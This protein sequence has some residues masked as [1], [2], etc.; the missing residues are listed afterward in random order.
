MEQKIILITGANSGIGKAAAQQ[1]VQKGNHTILACRNEEKGLAA[2]KEINDTTGMDNLE[3]MIMDMSLQS[4]IQ[5]LA[6]NFE[7]KFDHLDVIIH[8]AAIFDISQKE[9]SFTAEGVESIWATNHIGPVLL[10]RLLAN[11][12]EKSDHGRIITIASKGLMA[13]PFLKVDLVDPEFKAR[14]YSV[15]HAYYQSKLA[16]IMF[17]YWLAD[18]YQD[19]KI[20]ANSIYVTAVQVDIE[21]YP[22][23]PE[24][25]KKA[26][27][28][29]SKLSLTP[30]EMAQVYTHL[31]TAPE[32]EHVS[33]TVFDEKLRSVRTSKYSRDFRNIEEVMRLTMDYLI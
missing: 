7:E 31:A 17:T 24:L 18:Q 11:S 13:K 14:S 6:G 22:D 12:L 30:E 33:G 27:A 1:L 26:Y 20:T 28:L 16:Q 3:L 19:K 4:S 25:L 21:K 15:E 9:A 29:K 23:I 32:L 5:E 2:V 8:N 10:T